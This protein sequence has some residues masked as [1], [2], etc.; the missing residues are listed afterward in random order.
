L[1]IL[2]ILLSTIN[3]QAMDVPLPG[4]FDGWTKPVVTMS[5]DWQ[6][7]GEYSILYWYKSTQACTY[8]E[9]G[10]SLCAEAVPTAYLY[11]TST[12]GTA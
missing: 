11:F 2:N 10:Y 1:R 6:C 5:C 8:K 3:W 7:H 9:V 12:V 4:A